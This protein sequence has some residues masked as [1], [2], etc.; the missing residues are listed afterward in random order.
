MKSQPL[1]PL[2]YLS[3]ILLIALL[4]LP[5]A[6]SSS[7]GG[8]SPVPASVQ[9]QTVLAEVG[10]AR[11]DLTGA[12]GVLPTLQAMTP[13]N[14]QTTVPT[15]IA[16]AESADQHLGVAATQAASAETAAGKTEK[17][18]TDQQKTITELKAKNPVKDWLNWIGLG[19]IVAG[20]G[21]LIASIFVSALNALPWLRSACVAAILF[22]CFLLAIA[23]FLTAIMWI[24]FGLIGAAVV[25]GI[26]YVLTHKT[27]LSAIEADIEGWIPKPPAPTPAGPNITIT[28]GK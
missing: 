1:S 27:I 4:S 12:G 22:G 11:T 19:A 17:K 7:G 14:V 2:N 18:V 25:A 8:A 24:V 13:A 20:V 9:V 10:R 28:P 21:F 16:K 6:C 15:A 3:M 26:I 5:M 23:Y